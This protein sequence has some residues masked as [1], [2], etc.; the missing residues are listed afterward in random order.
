MNHNKR[1]DWENYLKVCESVVIRNPAK[2]ETDLF[3]RRVLNV[4]R[5]LPQ[6][7]VFAEK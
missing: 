7:W 6:Q 3:A 2:I 5:V 4:G 1:V